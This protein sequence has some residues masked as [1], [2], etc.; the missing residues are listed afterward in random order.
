M[1]AKGYGKRVM[2]KSIACK[3][4][5][6]DKLSEN[7]AATLQTSRSSNAREEGYQHI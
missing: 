5:L 1:T 4:V 7:G 2:A 3:Q 6:I